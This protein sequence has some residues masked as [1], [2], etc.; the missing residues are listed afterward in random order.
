MTWYHKN[1]A[2][3]ESSPMLLC[4]NESQIR[5][6]KKFTKSCFQTDLQFLKNGDIDIVRFLLWKSS[7][8]LQVL[9][10]GLRRGTIAEKVHNAQFCAQCGQDVSTKKRFFGSN[11]AILFSSFWIVLIL[12]I[13]MPS[14][15]AASWTLQCYV[16]GLWRYF[17]SKSQFHYSLLL[18]KYWKSISGILNK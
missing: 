11:E 14:L 6:N 4:A 5:W 2:F 10:E 12:S 13:Q 15:C 3:E 1:F 8:S 18:R 16:W 7:E 9:L 17:I